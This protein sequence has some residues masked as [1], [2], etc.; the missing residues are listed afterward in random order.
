MGW[1]VESL[2][3]LLK[4]LILAVG[5]FSSHN[6]IGCAIVP[7]LIAETVVWAAS[8]GTDFK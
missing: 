6:L 2:N 8:M 3:V 7:K 5:S 1:S 4:N